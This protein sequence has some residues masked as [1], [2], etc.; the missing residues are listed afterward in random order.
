[1]LL[2][3]CCR[4]KKDSPGKCWS[5]I[6]SEM[7]MLTDV[8]RAAKDGEIIRG[9]EENRQISFLHSLL[10]RGSGAGLPGRSPRS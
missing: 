8:A 7:L 3:L 5:V 4:V 6:D 9:T 2:L 1:M 10:K